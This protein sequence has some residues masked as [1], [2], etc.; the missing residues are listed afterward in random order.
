MQNSTKKIRRNSEKVINEVTNEI[1]HRV[2]NV[3]KVKVDLHCLENGEYKTKMEIN[4]K[5]RF[6]MASKIGHTFNES[7]NRT[8]RA[9]F[10]QLEKYRNK[11]RK[12]FYR[13][14]FSITASESV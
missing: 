5:G 14:S 11:K 12:M 4:V 8:K 3:R 7:L 10:K 9:A 1:K 6:F 13:E 2:P